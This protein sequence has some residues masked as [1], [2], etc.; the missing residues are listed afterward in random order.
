MNHSR[1]QITIVEDSK[2]NYFCFPVGQY[3]IAH[4]PH[5][6]SLSGCFFLQSTPNLQLASLIWQAVSLQAHG[7]TFSS[8]RY[9]PDSFSPC[10]LCWRCQESPSV[11][12]AATL[13]ETT[14]LYTKTGTEA[15][16]MALCAPCNPLSAIPSALIWEHPVAPLGIWCCWW[17]WKVRQY[18]SCQHVRTEFFFSEKQAESRSP[19]STALTWEKA[20]IRVST[21]DSL[22][23]PFSRE[24]C[25]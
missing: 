1:K 7:A 25:W 18:L 10:S 3:W 8:D 9:F 20:E 5:T 4:T 22:H 15:K 19:N 13:A 11:P 24:L 21:A 17:T 6:D 2:C 14:L 16:G 23:P 12:A